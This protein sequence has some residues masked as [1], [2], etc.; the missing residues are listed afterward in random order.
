MWE[1]RHVCLKMDKI[2]FILIIS[3]ILEIY[4]FK[5][6]KCDHVELRSNDNFEAFQGR[7]V[8]DNT[9]NTS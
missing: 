1:G 7:G 3:F 2:E 9:S 5:M 6:N 8:K 4:L